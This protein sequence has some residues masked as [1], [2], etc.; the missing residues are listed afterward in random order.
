MEQIRCNGYNRWERL[1]F[2][3][4]PVRGQGK[5]RLEFKQH[6]SFFLFCSEVQ[7]NEHKEATQ[8]YYSI[9]QGLH[10][11]V[12]IY[13]CVCCILLL[14]T[15]TLCL[16]IRCHNALYIY[17]FLGFIYLLVAHMQLCQVCKALTSSR[18]YLITMTINWLIDWLIDDVSNLL[19]SKYNIL[20]AVNINHKIRHS[21]FEKCCP[22]PMRC[23]LSALS[24]QVDVWCSGS[25]VKLPD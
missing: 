7:T 21:H 3:C 9:P 13:I 15:V 5:I 10:F 17:Y 25:W 2:D 22:L 11:T 20:M 6:T 8:L 4:F 14:R 23:H 24:R 18:C 1:H 16:I 19:S 12:C